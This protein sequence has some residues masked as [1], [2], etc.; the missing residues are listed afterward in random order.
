[1]KKILLIAYHFP[2]STEVGGVRLSNFAAQLPRAGW[3]VCVLT[4]KDKYVAEGDYERLKPLGE[5]EINKAGRLPTLCDAYLWFKKIVRRALGRPATQECTPSA[6]ANLKGRS[7]ESVKAK[8][9]RYVLSFLSLPDSQRNWVWP[10]VFEAV[11]IIKRNRIDVIL[12]S[13]PPYSTHLIGLIAKCLTNVQWVV[14]FRDPWMATPAK[15]L[16]ATCAAS[17]AVERWLEKKVIQNADLVVSN[18]DKLTN[19]FTATYSERGLSSAVTITNGY[20]GEMAAGFKNDVKDSVFTIAYAGTLYFGRTPEPIFQAVQNLIETGLIPRHAIRIKLVGQCGTIDGVPTEKVAARYGV[21]EIVELCGSVSRHD[22]LRL[23]KRSHVALL[24]APNQPFQIPAKLYEYMGANTVVLAIAEAGAT[25]ELV[26][27]TRA[28]KVFRPS[29]V[30]GVKDFILESYGAF[31]TQGDVPF[32]GDV[33]SFESNRITHSLAEYLDR[34]CTI[35][36]R[37]QW[38]AKDQSGRAAS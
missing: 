32:I 17:L 21:G 4:V 7:G 5:I 37:K 25:Q 11:S 36:S 14:D 24:L 19:Y 10:A 27:R 9:R 35:P 28:G 16:Y 15:S 38:L 13:C 34:I 18:T 8:L 20:D 22:A 2:P 26:E 23:I 1:M 33:E 29:D 6:R 30:A 31:V 12:T 3:R